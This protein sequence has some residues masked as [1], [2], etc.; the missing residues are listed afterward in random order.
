MA[1]RT[2]DKP[3]INVLWRS[4]VDAW[5]DHEHMRREKLPS[6]VLGAY[7]RARDLRFDAFRAGLAPSGI[8]SKAKALSAGIG[9]YLGD[10]SVTPVAA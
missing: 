7:A 4:F 5:D 1:T 9:F 10:G 2:I 3:Y 8:D 6:S